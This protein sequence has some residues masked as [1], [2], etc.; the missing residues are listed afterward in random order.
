MEW[1]SFAAFLAQ[2][3]SDEGPPARDGPIALGLRR[4]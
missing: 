4:G 1:V 2:R 3:D